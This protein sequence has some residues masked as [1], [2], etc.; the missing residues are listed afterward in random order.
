VA[1][2]DTALA[3]GVLDP[4]FG[5]NPNVVGSA[6]TSNIFGATTTTLYGIDSTLDLLVQQNPANSGTLLT[7]G[8]LGL[9][10]PSLLG[11]DISD[12]TG[13]AYAAWASS[14]YTIN[15][16]SGSASLVGQIGNGNQEIRGLA[17]PVPE[18]ALMAIGIGL[19]TAIR[20]RRVTRA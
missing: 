16:A 14:L 8:S 17:A 7:V 3:F 13:I 2:V 10:A 18:P 4:N 6:Y 5:A 11:F 12:R 20:R 15:L 9:N 19:L 1:I